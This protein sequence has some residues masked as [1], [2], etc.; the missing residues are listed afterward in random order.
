MMLGLTGPLAA[1]KGEACAYLEQKGF[2]FFSLSDIIRQEAHKQG[3]ETSRTNMIALG[4]EL[5][6]KYGSSV[7]AD[8]TL[9]NIRSSKAKHAVIDSVRNVHEVSALKDA[10][11]IMVGVD[12]DPKLRFKRLKERNRIGDVSTFQQL[13]EVEKQENSASDTEQQ[14]R[15]CFES[16]EYILTNDETLEELHS[17]IDALLE[18][19]KWK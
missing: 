5:R 2:V 19:L 12:A 13:V 10:G 8:R 17:Q 4:N 1:G 3:M 14:L 16:S 7:L 11:V 18:K 9:E 6:E 15:K